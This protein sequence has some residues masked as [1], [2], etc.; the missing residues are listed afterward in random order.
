[1][2]DV[3]RFP[4]ALDLASAQA[5]SDGRPADALRLL[6]AAVVRRA[7]V[8][9]GTPTFVVNNEEMIAE[10]RAVLA[11]HG[12]TDEG[13]RAWAEGETIDDDALVALIG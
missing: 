12:A 7:Q 13:N 11:E 1:M 9:G 3:A 10:A 6:S 8:G 2:R 5:I 4:L